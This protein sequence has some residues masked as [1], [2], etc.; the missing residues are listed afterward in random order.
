MIRKNIPNAITS[1]NLLGGVIASLFAATPFETSAGIPHYEW[2]WI[3]IGISAVADFLDGFVARLLHV[4]SELGKQLDSL[5]DLVSFGVAPAIL[6]LTVISGKS[7]SDNPWWAW[8]ALLIAVSGAIRL[9]KFNIDTRQTTTFLGLPIP[10]N[11]MF[12]IGYTASVAHGFTPLATPW[13]F[14][15]IMLIE[16]LLM[17]CEIPLLSLKVQN[18][19]LIDNIPRLLLVLGAGVLILFLGVEGLMWFVIYYLLLSYIDFRWGKHTRK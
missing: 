19:S 15:T 6:T 4:K 3:F 7:G 8:G 11:A 2:A 10:A 16:V 14:L 17:N 5:C 12:W 1:M 9:A 13:R 18:K